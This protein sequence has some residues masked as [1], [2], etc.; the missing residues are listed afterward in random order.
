MKKVPHQ[1]QRVRGQTRG[2]NGADENRGVATGA[3]GPLSI[4]DVLLSL[5]SR[6]L[7]FFLLARGSLWKYSMSGATVQLRLRAPSPKSTQM[8]NLSPSP[9]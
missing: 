7:R 6:L 3:R 5:R 9:R 8:V 4:G 2:T 1:Q